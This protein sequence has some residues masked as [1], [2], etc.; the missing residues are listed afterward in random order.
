MILRTYYFQILGI[1]CVLFSL[2]ATPVGIHSSS[3]VRMHLDKNQPNS[4]S[5]E[6]IPH[7]CQ[8]DALI[9]NKIY[10]GVQFQYD[11]YTQ[12][13][14]YTFTKDLVVRIR[15]FKNADAYRNYIDAMYPHIPKTWIGVY[16]SGVNEIL[17]SMEDDEE[18][19]FKNIFH[20]TCHLL[21]TDQVKNSPNWINE[22]LAEYF[23]FMQIQGNEVAVRL[24]P[25]KDSRTK[26]WVASNK[27]PNLLASIS[28]TNKEWNFN[29]NVSESDEPRTLGWSV[30]Y[31]LMS[32]KEGKRFI[33]DLLGY[34]GK[35]PNDTQ[36]SLR[37]INIYYP[38]GCQQMV[39]DWEQWAAQEHTRHVYLIH[40][41]EDETQTA[42]LD[43]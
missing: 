42:Q 37:A 38:G 16:L 10:R 15:I 29:D 33:K 12:Y 32:S 31:F 17:V 35:Y 8:L 34:L 13:L 6:L 3:I 39:Q 24:Q 21:L 23:E 43:R 28:M 11:F 27:V 41:T 36:A 1:I 9:Q 7:D 18:A 2:G 14:G 25:A 40:P 22:G 19:F 26:N 4:P 5:I 20:E 30:T